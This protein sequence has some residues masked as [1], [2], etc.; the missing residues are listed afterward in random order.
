MGST[1]IDINAKYLAVLMPSR[2]AEIY[3]F[4][5]K[6]WSE[7]NISTNESENNASSL[8][9]DPTN[10]DWLWIGGDHG[11]LTLVNL[12]LSQI[13]AQG[14]TASPLDTEW[15]FP[16]TN[17]VTFLVHGMPSGFGLYHLEKSRWFGTP[18]ETPVVIA[19]AAGQTGAGNGKPDEIKNVAAKSENFLRFGNAEVIA[20]LDGGS[21]TAFGTGGVLGQGALVVARGTSL[22]TFDWTGSFGF[23]SGTEFEKTSLPLKIEH[24]VTAIENNPSDLWLGTDGGGLIKIP[25]SGAAP[26]IFGMNDGLPMLSITSLRSTPDRLLIGFGH[27]RTG[28]MGYLDTNTLTFTSLTPPATATKTWEG[29]LQPSLLSPVLQIKP[30]DGTNTFWV[31]TA[32]ALYHLKLD[33]KQWTRSL[34]APDLPN[35]LGSAGLRTLSVSG[36]FAAAIVPSGGVAIRKLSDDQWTH[37]NLSTN[38]GENQVTT[39]AI[40]ESKP[41]HL[42]IGRRGRIIIVDPETRQIRAECNVAP[43]WAIEFMIIFSGDVFFVAAADQGGYELYHLDNPFFKSNR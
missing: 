16:T 20:N 9:F 23:G 2:C 37:L 42:W 14:E 43:P 32:Q 30:E 22:E 19:R 25:K 40:D 21:M 1:A 8:A 27:S 39:L 4:D 7:V 29:S 31:S 18:G 17:S 6:Q 28:A 24:P 26:R 10:P 34:P 13:L 12:E 41:P 3:R 11:T 5:T 33:S 36:G 15:I 35:Y 38:A